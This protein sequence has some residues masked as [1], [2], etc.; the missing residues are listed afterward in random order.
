MS[1]PPAKSERDYVI[2][3]TSTLVLFGLALV[4]LVALFAL[5][6]TDLEFVAFLS[7]FALLFAWTIWLVLVRPKVVYN[8]TRAKVVNILRTYE[9]PWPRVTKVEQRL[10]IV[11][12]LD[13]GRS[14]IAA[15]ASASR[16]PGVV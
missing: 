12:F 7:P 9:L 16:G 15:G 14:V 1:T 4:V 5:L 13:D 11:F 8:P 2:R 3:D 6:I 10:N